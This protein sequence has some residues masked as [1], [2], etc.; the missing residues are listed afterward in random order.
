ML[1]ILGAIAALPTALMLYFVLTD[2]GAA[3]RFYATPKQPIRDVKGPG[4]V[5]LAG[6]VSTNSKI[7]GPFSDREV[8]W[9]ALNVVE[10]VRSLDGTRIRETTTIHLSEKSTAPFSITDASGE[11]ARIVVAGEEISVT[12]KAGVTIDGGG[13]PIP[14][15]IQAVLDARGVVTRDP[16]GQRKRLVCTEKHILVGDTITLIGPARR[17]STSATEASSYRDAPKELV[18]GER[19]AERHLFLLTTGP[20]SDF[21]SSDRTFVRIAWGLL[22]STVLLLSVGYG[23]YRCG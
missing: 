17:V 20:E 21:S 16:D 18:V 15:R 3:T 7:V 13:R 9:Y 22:A 2:D 5:K 19:G 1:M 6:T 12:T 11:S 23:L 4:T 14:P 10:T 8:A